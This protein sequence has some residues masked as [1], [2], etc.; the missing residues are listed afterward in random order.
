LK[1]KL[2]LITLIL[3][4]NYQIYDGEDMNEILS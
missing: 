1:Y 2:N 3:Q 4:C